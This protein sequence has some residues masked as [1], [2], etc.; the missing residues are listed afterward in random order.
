MQ[1][2]MAFVVQC[3]AA[4]RGGLVKLEQALMDENLEVRKTAL[5][6]ILDLM[7]NAKAAILERAWLE[8]DEEFKTHLCELV[9]RLDR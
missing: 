8:K 5:A 1:N 9:E 3:A 6:A 4:M 7:E 2:K